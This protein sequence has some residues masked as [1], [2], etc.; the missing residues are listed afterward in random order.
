MI[1]YWKYKPLGRVDF[2]LLDQMD[3]AVLNDLVRP[4]WKCDKDRCICTHMHTVKYVQKNP[5]TYVISLPL[6]QVTHVQFPLLDQA[7]QL[8]LHHPEE[9]TKKAQWE[10]VATTYQTHQT[11]LLLCCFVSTCLFY[12]QL[13]M[14]YLLTF[15][16]VMDRPGCPGRPT[17]P[18]IPRSPW[19]TVWIGNLWSSL[20][21]NKS[22]KELMFVFSH[23]SGWGG[24]NI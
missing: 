10:I 22:T 17:W 8:D 11:V 13:I 14:F 3:L 4:G 21:W 24:I 20:L 23:K 6:V 2:H 1:K 15:G 18:G 7:D 16:P 12:Y 19:K 9:R 5:N